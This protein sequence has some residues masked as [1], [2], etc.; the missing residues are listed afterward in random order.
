MKKAIFLCLIISVV[1]VLVLASTKVNATDIIKAID[2]GADVSYQNAEIMGDL[3]FTAIK[4][5]TQDRTSKRDGDTFWCHVKSRLEFKNCVFNGDVIGYFHDDL[6]KDLYNAEFQK[7][8]IF[9]DCTFRGN[10]TFKYSKFFEKANFDNARFHEES[11]FKYTEFSDK[12]SF[13]GTQFDEEANFKYTKLSTE[14]RFEGAKFRRVAT[15]KYTKFPEYVNFAE[16]EFR[17]DANFK[18]AKFPKGVSFQDVVF[19]KDVNFKYT[20]F[21]E[22]ANFDGTVFDGDVDLKHTKLDGEPF[23]LYLLKHR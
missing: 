8:V 17:R 10:G 22:P 4:D 21:S 11:N 14:I 6:K 23:S 9:E 1:P 15:F 2:K 20:K 5:V 7:D 13:R 18:Y 19:S 12:A 3:D 16:A